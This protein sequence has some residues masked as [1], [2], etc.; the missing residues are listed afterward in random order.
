MRKLLF[1][2]LGLLIAAGLLLWLRP[3]AAPP[4]GNPAVAP[5]VT[6]AVPAAAPKLFQLR[7][8]H[9]HLVSGPA[10]LTVAQGDRVVI[11]VVVDE[12]EQLHLHGYNRM[13]T[14]AAGVPA[15]LEFVADRSGRFDYELERSS[16]ELGAL[17]VQPR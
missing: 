1:V 13:V 4:V 5:A 16:T 17:E 3:P 10:T 9:R 11:E 12:A 8:E 6:P 2:A 15:R 7:V 14:L